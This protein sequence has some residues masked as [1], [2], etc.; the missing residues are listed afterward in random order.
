MTKTNV[1]SHLTKTKYFNM[2]F[3]LQLLTT[4]KNKTSAI[5]CLKNDTNKKDPDGKLTNCSPC[6]SW[7]RARSHRHQS[8]N[9]RRTGRCCHLSG[10][11]SPCLDPGNGTWKENP[12]GKS[13]A[14]M[15]TGVD[16]RG[17]VWF[18]PSWELVWRWVILLLWKHR[19][20]RARR[21][22]FVFVF[23]SHCWKRTFDFILAGRKG[24]AM[25]KAIVF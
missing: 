6:Q 21:W 24:N 11:S 14:R 9:G 23:T 4:K 3:V 13:D 10:W 25:D 5:L 7:S 20:G 18:M 8:R 19:K 2:H 22:S 17:V 16:L 1:A 15:A 12:W